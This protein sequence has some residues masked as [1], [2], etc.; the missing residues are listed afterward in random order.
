M[1]FLPRLFA[2]SLLIATAVHAQLTEQQKQYPLEVDASD[3]SLSKIVLIAGDISNNKVGG[4]EYFAGCTVL[5]KTLK[6]TPGV[7]P[8]MAAEGWPKNEAIFNGAKAIVIYTDG[9]DKLPWLDAARW[10]KIRAAV[11]GG[12]GFVALHQAVEVPA[13][14]ANE[15]KSWLGAVWQKDIGCRGHWDMTLKTTSTHPTLTGVTG[16][17]APHD[18]WLFNLHFNDTGVTPLLIGQVP[19][20][21]RSTADAKAHNGRDEV[22][23]WAY[24]RK[25]GG[26][27]IGF[28]GADLHSSW[29]IDSQRRFIANAILWSAKLNVPAS[30][31]AIA[32]EEADFTA[33]MDGKTAAAKKEPATK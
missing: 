1:H 7:W 17:D 8:V 28:T 2:S 27:S 26:R 31:A 3:A 4:H 13:D 10:A 16:F 23:A 30:G 6:Q 19:D 11:Q 5:M 12:A 24:E 9:G 22:I 20:K 33:Y 25:D 32:A 14:H 29:H 15:Y 18:G 21:G